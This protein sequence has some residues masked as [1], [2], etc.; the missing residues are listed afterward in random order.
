MT[1]DAAPVVT[2]QTA[3][4]AD[5]GTPWERLDRRAFLAGA[6]YTAV[7]AAGAALITGYWLAVGTSA[8]T[9]LAWVLPAFVVTV[10]AGGASGEWMWRVTRYR[11]DAERLHVRTGTVWRK[12]L[13]LRRERIRSVD[14]TADPVLRVLGAVTVRVGTGEHAGAEGTATLGRRPV[15][16]PTRSAP[17]C[18]RTP[19]APP[20]STIPTP[21]TGRWPGSTAGGSGSPRCPSSRRRWARPPRAARSRWP[22]G[23]GCRRT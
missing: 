11:V 10:A 19:R 23:S 2:E 1:D 16:P 6:I 8:G 9:A 3:N 22:S 4:G 21:A 12:R 15:R 5:D 18:W 7:P 14:L 13:A 20:A 17:P